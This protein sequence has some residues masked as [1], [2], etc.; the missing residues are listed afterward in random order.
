MTALTPEQ[1]AA[2][3]TAISE[4]EAALHKVMTGRVVSRI[5]D[6]NG[7]TVTFSGGINKTSLR[8]YIKELKAMLPGEYPV[9]SVAPMGFI[10]GRM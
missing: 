5:T 7:E 10:F 1:K 8:A 3:R 4:A 9:E 2:I 6:Q